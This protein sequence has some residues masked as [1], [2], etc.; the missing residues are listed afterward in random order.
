MDLLVSPI[1][2]LFQAS[3]LDI[4]ACPQLVRSPS[5][6]FSMN[7]H[8]KIQVPITGVMYISAT[9]HFIMSFRELC[10][11]AHLD[12]LVLFNNFIIFLGVVTPWV[13][14][15]TLLLFMR[16]FHFF[17]IK[18]QFC[19]EYSSIS[20]IA[21]ESRC[22]LMVWPDLGTTIASGICLS[23]LQLCFSLDWLH[24]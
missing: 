4:M 3:F 11:V 14:F 23:H 16:S 12:N 18:K 9:Y 10:R 22:D 24:F 6:F 13:F 21:T 8:V 7:L 2:S 5:R 19:S 15:L 17:T 20:I 1:T